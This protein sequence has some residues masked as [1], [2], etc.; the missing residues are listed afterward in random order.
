MTA[1]STIAVV[2]NPNCG[3]TTL[4]NALTGSHQSVGN[5]P[6]VTVEKKVG[7]FSLENKDIALVDLPGIYSIQPS[8][9]SS[10]DERVARNYILEDEAELIV[11]IV[12]ASNLERNL[13]LTAQLIEMQVPMVVAVNMLDAA[14]HH[15]ISIDLEKLSKELD[16]PVVGL[17]ASKEK[18]IENLKKCI[19]EQLVKKAVPKNPI[20]FPQDINEE[21]LSIG[22]D[23]NRQ[24]ISRAYW[25][26]EQILEGDKELFKVFPDKNFAGVEFK[27][28]A[29]NEKYDGDVDMVMADVRYSFVGRVAHDC[30]TRKGEATQT[31]TDKIDKVVLHRWLGVP[32]FLGVMY[33]MFIFSINVGSAFID[34]FDILFGAIF[35]DGFGELLTSIGT[36]EWLKTI[37]ADGIGGGIQCVATFI[38]VIFCLFLALSFL[39]DSGYMAR[40][41]FVMDRLMR[42]LGLPGKAFVPL[43][44][45]FGCGVPAIMATRTMEKKKD[46]ITTVLMAPFMS[47]GARLP[48]YVLFA[49][50]FWP[51]NGQN[52][53]F[54]LY[55]IGILAAIA[56]GFM[57]KKA[58]LQGET[59]AFV[60]EIP[61][62]HLPTFKNIILRTWDRLK[63]FI[64]R[65][66][67]VIVVLVAVLCF[68]NSLGTDGSFGNEDSD[69]SVL[70]QIG[71]TIVPVFKP[72]GVSE[73]NWPAAVGIFT[74]ILAKEAVVG[75]LDSLYSGMGGKDEETAAEGAPAAAIEE[76]AE[77]AEE[78]GG[79]NFMNS[80]NEAVASIG[81]GFGD[82]GA[83]FTDPLGIS[84]DSDLSDVEKQAEE[85][86]VAAGTIQ[87]MNKLYDGEL[88]AFA[89]LLM[90]L[91]YLPCG[92]AMGAVYREVGSKW[93]LFAA[94]W[95]TVLGYCSATL[96]YQV[97]RFS[98]NPAYASVCIAVCVAL[99]AAVVVGLRMAANND[100]RGTGEA[101]LAR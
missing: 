101:V 11:N 61:P 39:E 24:G 84:V 89:Y 49:T 45:G 51:M 96:V 99:I 53:V 9:S 4:F 2:G 1:K 62:Y 57:L 75:T 55:L 34:F 47:C 10:E 22:Q 63:G 78:E 81:E 52:L 73:E 6:G 29:L 35:I 77:A 46:R 3:K 60:M 42:A 64:F 68:L 54:G 50:A 20:V 27:A 21:I 65:A 56:T 30:I 87:A 16:C 82:I 59:S 95:T 76:K 94:G 37:L 72:M 91:L 79:F 92:A 43:I 19:E 32:I 31:L 70:S 80:L 97:G 48:V 18:G 58:V 14:K 88:G 38:P 13:Y 41:A 36:P 17:I 12:D 69:K 66:G 26:A 90:V 85:Q 67:K 25:V 93:A 100:E 33:L 71:K 44:I 74:G 8:A 15:G 23:L 5:W 83:F 7:H 28:N 86:E 40:A 98:S